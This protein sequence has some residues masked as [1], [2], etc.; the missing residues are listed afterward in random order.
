VPEAIVLLDTDDRILQVNP[1]FTRMFGYAP[2]ETCGRLINELVVPE[3][4]LAEAVEYTRRG[5]RGESLN[6]EAVRKHKD[7]TR[8][9]V[10]IVSGPASIAG[11]QICEYV[12]YRDITKRKR[13]EQRLHESEAYL[14]E[15]QRLSQTGSWAWSPAAGDIR[16]WSDTCYRVLGFDP[17][18]PLPRFEEFFRRIHPDDQAALSERF[19]QAIRDKADFEL[20]YRVVHP[21]EGI[22]DIHA[23]GHAV[24][25]GS[26]NLGEFVGTVID[27]TERKRAEQELRQSET[28]LRTKNDRLKLLLNLTSQ[29]TSNLKLHEL[30]RAVSSNIREVMQ[31]DAVFVSLVDSASGTPRLYVLDFPQSKGLIKE[32]IVYT[33]S[34]VGKRVVETLKPAVVDL[35]DP[36]AV[37][38]EIYDRVIAEGLKSACLIPLVNRGRVLGGLVVARKIETSFTPAD[39][40]F[41]SQASGQIAIAIENAFAFQEVSGLRDRLQLLLNLTTKITSSLDLREVLRAVAANV[42]E[43]I[44]ADAVAVSLPDAPSGKFRVFAVDFPHGRGVIKEELLYTPGAASRKAADTMKPVVGCATDVD[45][46]ESS[47]VRNIA[48]AEGMKAFCLIPLVSRGRFLGILS[49]LRTTETPFT[50]QDVDLLT[51]ASGQ[52][53]IAVENALAYHEISELKNKLAQEK[54]YLEEEEKKLREL[55]ETIPT[56]AWTALPDG[57]EDFVNRYWQEYSGLSVEESAGLGW[58]AAVHPADLK[59]HLEKWRTSLATGEPFENEVRYR[60]AAD[61]QYRWF[62]ARA[63]PLRDALGKILK[64]Y[65][66]SIDIE[67]RKRAEEEIRCEMNF[68]NIVGSSSPLKHVLELVEI[69]APNDSTVLLLGETGTGKELIARAIHDQS[70]RKDRTFVK[71]NCAAIPTGL[72]ESELFGHEKG[73]FTGAITQRIGRMEL[74]DQGT[75]FLDEVGDIPIEI[76]PKL[77]RALQEREFE[78]LGSTHTRRANIRL[79]A[80]TNRDLEKMIADREFRSDLYYRLN[81]FPIRVPPLRERKEDI[82]QL[83]SYFVQKFASQMQKKIDSISPV[84]MGGLTTWEWPGNIRELENFIERAVI[85]TRGRSL[86]PPLGEL[87]KRNTVELPQVADRKVGPLVGERT[88]LQND[89]TSIADDYERKQRDE[90]IRA[91][92]ACKGRV[93]G[94]DGAAACLGVN[95]TTLL[96]RM[97]KFGIYAKQYA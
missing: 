97:K 12:I 26:G 34:R 19:E 4:L 29:I 85:L 2:E 71:L 64:W 9:H 82:P 49:I 62:L 61:G 94:A 21:E 40:E 6:V 51:Q 15:A 52:I 24:L 33:V 37:P 76:Q 28:D 32:E 30:L 81:V 3:E 78:R 86:E 42:R 79:I 65:G 72:L 38:P 36:A 69:V 35:S 47:E 89:K 56:H 90:I 66:I 31:C 80:A 45:E 91:L 87:R 8:V 11:S 59:G 57:S 60:C 63:V 53:A 67:D 75:L 50:P 17:A 83:V 13:A 48:A 54:L 84:V 95:R 96:A 77:L 88:N 70:R 1:E 74:A 43:L 92:A 39:V 93:G 41:L 16:Y 23:V 10:S 46:R 14:A 68:E 55:I 58:Q 18:G 27:V 5:L 20:D 44:H 7:G 25:D 73:A 22:R